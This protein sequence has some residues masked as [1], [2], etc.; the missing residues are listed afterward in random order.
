MH[1]DSPGEAGVVTQHPS[2]T[3]KA[4]FCQLR[5]ICNDETIYEV[6]ADIIPPS[7]VRK[8]KLA[9]SLNIVM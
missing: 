6:K 5:L 4:I 9:I 7:K 1:Q 8:N 3:E 2:T